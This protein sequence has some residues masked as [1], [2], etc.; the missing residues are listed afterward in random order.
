LLFDGIAPAISGYDGYLEWGSGSWQ[1][2]ASTTVDFDWIGYGNVCNLPQLLRVFRAG[3]A[4]VLAWSTNAF[5][6]VLQSND[7]L[8]ANWMDV[9]NNI[10][11]VGSAKTLTYHLSGTNRFFRLR[12][13]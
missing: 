9:T 1:F 13:L 4:V 11:V 7:N 2:T 12:R 8:F 3:N 6:F 5:G 10:S